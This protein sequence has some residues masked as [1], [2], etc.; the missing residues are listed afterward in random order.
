MT[1]DSLFAAALRHAASLR[2]HPS[3]LEIE[4]T[5]G[6]IMT[7]SY[8][9]TE[10]LHLLLPASPTEEMLRAAQVAAHALCATPVT[11]QALRGVL[12][13]DEDTRRYAQLNQIALR[14]GADGTVRTRWEGLTL[15]RSLDTEEWILSLP[16]GDAPA[17]HL[18][19]AVLA[20]R[21]CAMAP[22]PEIPAMP[23]DSDTN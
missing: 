14:V 19:N 13:I 15:S 17:G 18:W 1:L 9:F 2:P 22:A 7:L 21:V 23:D 3:F 5:P 16:E 10:Q 6:T 20:A 11:T 12:M 8:G 4:T